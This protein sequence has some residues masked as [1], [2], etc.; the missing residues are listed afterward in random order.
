M[1]PI[2]DPIHG[3]IDVRPSI[4]KLLDTKVVQRLRNVKQL[5]WT[6]LVYPGANH[7]RYE[8]SIGTYYLAGRLTAGLTGEERREIEIAA[9]L[10][11]IGHGPYSHDCEEVIEKYAR[12]THTE[13]KFLLDSPE[14]AG[15]IEAQGIK[16]SVIAA[17]IQGESRIGQIINGTLDVDRMDYLIRDAY[18]TGVSY[19]IVDVEHLLRNLGFHDNMLVLYHRG[20]KSAEAL[21][22]SRFLMYPSV[23]NHHV[24][25][26]AGAMYVNA[27]EVAIDSGRL[28]PFELQL[29]DDYE[30]NV[31]TRNMT[32]YPGEI[33]RRLNRRELFKRALYVG[34]DSVDRTIIRYTKARRE[35]EAEIARIAGIDKGYVLVDIPKVP[36]FRERNMRVLTESDQLKYID[37]VSSLARIVEHSYTDDWR[38]GVYT[39][40][41]YREKVGQIARDYFN[42][43]K[44]PRQSKLEVA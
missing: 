28:D 8:H 35:I 12:R 43:E 42:V 10:H 22:M 21:L 39:L 34:F 32:G 37:D 2:R 26:I 44:A 30:I 18:Y 1:S 11:D 16:P 17:H 23:Y 6:N 38:M 15:I 33:L 5:G 27:L 7:T 4:E 13:I 25:R 20:L 9:L 3:Y 29:M 14:I 31:R 41:E 36:E 40:P 19:G 24:G